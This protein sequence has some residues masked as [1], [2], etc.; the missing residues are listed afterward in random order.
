MKSFFALSFVALLLYRASVPETV[1]AG[2]NAFFVMD[3][4]LRDGITRSPTEQAGL[5]KL[6]G[7]DGFGTSGYPEDELL[8]AFEK[9]GLRVY[10]T[11][12]SLDFDSASLRL[13][14]K[15][16]GLV[17]RLKPHHTDLWISVNV[18]MRDGMKLK[19]SAVEG[20]AIVAPHCV[21]WQTWQHLT[22]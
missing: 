3:T 4:A 16:P 22:T 10:N 2:R 5:V 19:P 9:E 17:S 1:A 6:L 7:F 12:L 11:Y 20:D 18:V 14:Q 13:D 15:L 8:A 21:N